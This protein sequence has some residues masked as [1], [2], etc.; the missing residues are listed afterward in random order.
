MPKVQKKERW[1]EMPLYF[2]SAG[3]LAHGQNLAVQNATRMTGQVC[4]QIM[5]M[6]RA[7]FNLWSALIIDFAALPWRY[8]SAQINYAGDVLTS[9]EV[10]GR[11]MG[12]LVLHAEEE[13]GDALQE[14]GR[15][16]REWRE[17]PEQVS[18]APQSTI[19][20]RRQRSERAKG[21]RTEQ[22]EPDRTH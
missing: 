10:T 2:P 7:W 22:S 9:F 6:N 21:R 18:S 11:E 15:G 13:A 8:T 5:T 1:D 3:K 4:H 16:I 19:N 14:A 20:P 17:A 12:N